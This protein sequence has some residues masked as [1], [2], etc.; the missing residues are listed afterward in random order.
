MLTE[1]KGQ[2]HKGYEDYEDILL[3]FKELFRDKSSRYPRA[4]PA[5]QIQLQVWLGSKL[6]EAASTAVLTVP[7]L[8]WDAKPGLIPFSSPGLMLSVKVVHVVYKCCNPYS[9]TK[10]NYNKKSNSH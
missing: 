7:S 9:I 10:I 6:S 8:L 3:S 5:A 2:T 1:L 4:L